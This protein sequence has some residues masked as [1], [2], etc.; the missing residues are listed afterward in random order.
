MKERVTIEEKKL[1]REKNREHAQKSRLKKRLLIETL[2][3]KV[4]EL[5]KENNKLR[6]II[7][8]HTSE[9]SEA[10]SIMKRI[11]EETEKDMLC[12]TDTLFDE[13]HSSNYLRI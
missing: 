9:K 6:E 5:Q 10:R 13:Y 12:A 2:E 11:E 8:E 1:R 4:Q 7:K 3:L